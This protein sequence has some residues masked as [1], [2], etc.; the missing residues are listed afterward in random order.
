M[1]RLSRETWLAIALFALLTL[2]TGY[3]ALR[4]SE[5]QLNIPL[6][7]RSAQ[8]LGAK[9]LWLWLDEIG[10]QV[11]D[12]VTEEYAIPAGAELVI[13]LEPLYFYP[14]LD[15]EMDALEAW[16]KAGGTVLIAGQGI[17]TSRL[18][19]HFDFF[20]TYLQISQTS[21]LP[22]MPVLTNPPVQEIPAG[23]G[24]YFTTGRTDYLPLVNTTQGPA[25]VSFPHGEGQVFLSTTTTPFTNAGL[26]KPGNAELVLNLLD[27]VPARS[28]IWFDEWHHGRRP[29]L[30]DTGWEG[31]GNWLRKTPA[32]HAVL[33]TTLVIFAW[34]GITGRRFG[35]PIAPPTETR[36]R[37]PLEYVTAIANLN[38]RAGNRA[39]LLDHYHR[40]IK[41]KLGKRYRLDP[42]LPDANYLAQLHKFNASLDIQ[43]LQTL[44]TQLRHPGVSESE[45][46]RLANEAANWLK[47]D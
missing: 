29:T 21:L 46:V 36:R 37:T 15:E 32:G 17:E 30:T 25:I 45:M 19:A 40:Q 11:S 18:F 38:R 6:E 20:D 31:P 27:S 34:I 24:L 5:S 39:A 43:A 4:Q 13:I 23:T 41:R 7:N 16:V 22:G 42:A 47:E 14:H 35:K 2:V 8:P 9:A 10:Y 12:R 44:L 1:T 26:K 3:A 28:L 33:Y